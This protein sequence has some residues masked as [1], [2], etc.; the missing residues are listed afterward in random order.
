MRNRE[1]RHACRLWE[2]EL[3]LAVVGTS[4]GLSADVRVATVDRQEHQV[5]RA[6]LRRLL[7]GVDH[8]VLGG[9][10][11]GR[12]AE[13]A[14]T[15]HRAEQLAPGNAGVIGLDQRGG[16]GRGDGGA[17]REGEN[18]DGQGGGLHGEHQCNGGPG[19]VKRRSVVDVEVG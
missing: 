16:L 3:P 5:R 6:H 4:R 14:P 9:H 13:D 10:R 1:V 15:S 18:G 19:A 2:I 12:P 7:S 11:S 17:S 8:R